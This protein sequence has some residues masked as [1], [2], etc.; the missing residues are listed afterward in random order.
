MRKYLHNFTY[1][2]YPLLCLLFVCNTSGVTFSQNIKLKVE[3]LGLQIYQPASGEVSSLGTPPSQDCAGFFSF[4]E[5]II[6]N[7]LTISGIDY[8]LP[9]FNQDEFGWYLTNVYSVNRRLYVC[10]WLYNGYK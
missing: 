3:R 2:K 4:P 6:N 9:E 10:G 8:Q 1:I 7:K 5:P